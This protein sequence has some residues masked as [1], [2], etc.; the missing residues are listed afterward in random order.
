[1]Q[2]Q[3]Y[4]ALKVNS[5]STVMKKMCVDRWKANLSTNYTKLKLIPEKLNNISNA[6]AGKP[7]GTSQI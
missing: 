4:I 7:I 6:V 1:M 2:T 3:F 5:N